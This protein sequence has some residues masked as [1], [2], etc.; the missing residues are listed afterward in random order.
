[1]FHDDPDEGREPKRFALNKVLLYY[2]WDFVPFSTH[3][4]VGE[5]VPNLHLVSREFVLLN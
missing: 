5:V 1:M 4:E 3:L 2:K